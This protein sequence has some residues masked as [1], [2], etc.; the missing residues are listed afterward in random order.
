MKY[1]F[2]RFLNFVLF[3]FLSAHNVLS[4][5]DYTRLLNQNIKKVIN[6]SYINII[7]IDKNSNYD[8]IILFSIDPD[9]SEISNTVKILYCVCNKFLHLVHLD[10]GLFEVI[11][12][13]SYNTKKILKFLVSNDA[14]PSEK[15]KNKIKFLKRGYIS[16]EGIPSYIANLF[17]SK[18]LFECDLKLFGEVKDDDELIYIQPNI[19]DD[20]SLKTWFVLQRGQRNKKNFEKKFIFKDEFNPTRF[21]HLHELKEENKKE[22]ILSKIQNYCSEKINNLRCCFLKKNNSES[23]NNEEAKRLL[24]NKAK[25]N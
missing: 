3:L 16:Y 1:I 14:L 2:I 23:I 15:E 6:N 22:S 13:K 25:F 10:I 12:D 17:T 8:Y 5:R 19:S 24:P 20:N 11:F 21:T 4:I 9:T 7:K 18:S